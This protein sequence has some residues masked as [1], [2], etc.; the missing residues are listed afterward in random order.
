[1]HAFTSDLIP[2]TAR[3]LL[4]CAPVTPQVQVVVAGGQ[5]LREALQAVARPQ[6]R[7]GQLHQHQP[8]SRTTSRCMMYASCHCSMQD[9]KYLTTRCKAACS[10]KHCNR[11][12]AASSNIIEARGA[13][14]EKLSK[15][16]GLCR[17]HTMGDSAAAS[18]RE[19][20]ARC[21]A[22]VGRQYCGAGARSTSQS[23][24]GARTRSR[25]NGLDKSRSCFCMSAIHASQEVK[26]QG[27]RP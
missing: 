22:S 14:A 24:I 2:A 5:L 27:A 1:M 10:A 9:W 6:L 18:A 11:R 21:G 13:P 19:V 20:W 17:A 16:S 8:C 3:A 7:Q 25:P 26:P 12:K 15:R 4:C 23:C